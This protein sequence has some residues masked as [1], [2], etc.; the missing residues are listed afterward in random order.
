MRPRKQ[1]LAWWTTGL[2]FAAEWLGYILLETAMGRLTSLHQLLRA[3]PPLILFFLLGILCRGWSLHS[4]RLT[5]PR[6]LALLAILLLAADQLGKVV[7]GALLPPGAQTPLV[8][9][10]LEMGNVHNLAGSYLA[11]A[12]LKPLLVALALLLLP[13]AFIVYCFYTS[14]RNSLWADLALLGIAAAYASWLC[15]AWRG[16]T[17]D[18]I[19]VPGV[20]AAD[21]KD[22]YALVGGASVVVEALRTS[23]TLTPD[24]GGWNSELTS[25]RTTMKELLDFGKGEVR[26]LWRALRRTLGHGRN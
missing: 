3:L 4:S 22:L 6:G 16:Y 1:A 20:V 19:V 18:F 7:V 23:D 9:G 11:P 12:V 8:P 5:E 2:I 13:A 25:L 26:T 21:L 15:D 14:R 17:L 10:W 24:K